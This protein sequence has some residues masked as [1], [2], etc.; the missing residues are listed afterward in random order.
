V[1]AL[2][3]IPAIIRSCRAPELLARC[4]EHLAARIRPAV[5]V[6]IGDSIEN[7]LYTRAINLGLKQSLA[8]DAPFEPR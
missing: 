3:P 8:G 1:R 7:R 5:P 2:A 4:I 6:V